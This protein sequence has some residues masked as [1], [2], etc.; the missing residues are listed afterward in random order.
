M[1]HSPPDKDV[2][3]VVEHDEES[4][5]ELKT[6]H[7]VDDALQFVREHDEIDWTP[8][9]ERKILWKIDIRIIVLVSKRAPTQRPEAVTPTYHL[10]AA[11]RQYLYRLRQPGIRCGGNLWHD[12]GFEALYH[13]FARSAGHGSDKIFM[14]ERDLGLWKPHR[15]YTPPD[16]SVQN[17][18]D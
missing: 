10:L 2:N 4:V 5:Q 16:T 13:H 9:E 3:T 11:L 6:G 7:A 17:H 18:Q 8:E 1:E 12:P 15:T 14:D